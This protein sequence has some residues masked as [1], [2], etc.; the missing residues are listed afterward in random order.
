MLFSFLKST[1][2]LS[3]LDWRQV[4]KMQIKPNRL[5]SI[6]GY[7]NKPDVTSIKKNDDRKI[8]SPDYFPLDDKTLAIQSGISPE[9]L[10]S[11]K[12][13]EVNVFDTL[14]EG[15]HQ[16]AIEEKAWKVMCVDSEGNEQILWVAEGF[17]SSDV[18]TWGL[19][20]S[21]LGAVAD[22][23]EEP[24]D[25]D[26]ATPMVVRIKNVDR[27]EDIKIPEEKTLTIVMKDPR[28]RRGVIAIK[29]AAILYQDKT[30]GRTSMTMS[31]LSPKKLSERNKKKPKN[32]KKIEEAIKKEVQEHP[33]A[34][35]LKGS[36]V[37][38]FGNSLEIT[39]R[40]QVSE[41]EQIGF[42]TMPPDIFLGHFNG[43][44]VIPLAG[45]AQPGIWIA[46][47]DYS[48]EKL[49]NDKFFDITK[50]ENINI[51]RS[52]LPKDTLMYAVKKIEEDAYSVDIYLLDEN[53][54]KMLVTSFKK[55]VISST[56]HLDKLWDS[57]AVSDAF[58][59]QEKIKEY[60]KHLKKIGDFCKNA[61]EKV[62]EGKEARGEDDLSIK[63]ID[64]GVGNSA[65]VSKQILDALEEVKKEY[66]EMYGTIKLKVRLTITDVN[67]YITDKAMTKIKEHIDCLSKIN[68]DEIEIRKISYTEEG[69]VIPRKYEK[70]M[71]EQDLLVSNFAL[72]Y[73]DLEKSIKDLGEKVAIGGQ[74]VLGLINKKPPYKKASNVVITRMKKMGDFTDLS[75]YRIIGRVGTDAERL[76]LLSTKAYCQFTDTEEVISMLEEAGFRVVATERDTF[77]G[78]GKII[79][80]ECIRVRRVS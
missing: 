27:I 22:L 54:E 25:K 14:T 20:V 33:N 59:K 35:K 40:Y 80:G 58:E 8:D 76:G 36:L 68:K 72:D 11:T 7:A 41:N 63:I 6:E 42:V 37:P 43:F 50:I 62:F 53:S 39:N 49:L 16:I 30:I 75:D 56:K 4:C 15:H 69:K 17:N 55:I 60:K 64:F 66:E 26:G 18:V 31:R 48:E 10:Q 71:G 70:E 57:K 65:N 77:F 52:V 19:Q 5:V 47:A 9:N 13:E 46:L 79:S 67:D 34:K 29:D 12:I 73:N 74:V 32:Q 2:H 44:S 45:T 3:C 28:K 61:I 21:Q 38:G 78:I 51:S 23:S 1:S 24:V